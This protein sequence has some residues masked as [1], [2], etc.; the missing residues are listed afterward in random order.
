[1]AE[2]AATVEVG[3]DTLAG[4]EGISAAAGTLAEVPD[5]SAVDTSADSRE[6]AMLAVDTSAAG[7]SGA[8]RITA[9]EFTWAVVSV[10]RGTSAEAT[11]LAML[12]ATSA[13]A[14]RATRLAIT[15]VRVTAH[16]G[17]TVLVTDIIP[18]VTG[19]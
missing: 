7:T 10:V 4:V 6:E 8:R 18:A 13:A 9:A 17:I 3:E 5:T 12:A 15:R 11:P 1:M 2:G 14:T 19:I 16:M